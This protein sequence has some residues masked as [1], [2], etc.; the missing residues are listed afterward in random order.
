MR[1]LVSYWVYCQRNPHMINSEYMGSIFKRSAAANAFF[2]TLPFWGVPLVIL[3]VG[4]SSFADPYSPFFYIGISSMFA[5]WGLLVASKWDQIR[6]GDFSTFGI[7]KSHPEM[8]SL[9]R[10]SYVVMFAGWILACF[11]GALPA[12]A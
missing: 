1:S 6:H 7:S 8:R 11:S 3:V 5:G 9:Y 10:W 2:L 4:L 12:I